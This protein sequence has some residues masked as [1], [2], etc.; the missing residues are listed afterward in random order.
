MTDA[1][2]V[3]GPSEPPPPLPERSDVIQ[4]LRHAIST[5][6]NDDLSAPMSEKRRRHVERVSAMRDAIDL[7]SACDF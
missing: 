1:P 3:D 5:A 6:S 4:R 2:F 7:L